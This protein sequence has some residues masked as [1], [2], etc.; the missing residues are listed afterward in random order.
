MAVAVA[1]ARGNLVVAITLAILTVS[2]VPP[3]NQIFLSMLSKSYQA[4]PKKAEV[5]Y[6]LPPAFCLRSMV[7]GD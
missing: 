1:I 4:L 3:I 2:F 7:T 6:K 5:L